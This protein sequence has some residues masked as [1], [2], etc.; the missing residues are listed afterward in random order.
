MNCVLS[1]GQLLGLDADKFNAEDLQQQG[2]SLLDGRLHAQVW[3][4]CLISCCIEVAKMRHR[5]GPAQGLDAAK[6]DAI[7]QQ[8]QRRLLLDGPPLEASLRN[9]LRL[10]EA[11]CGVKQ[12]RCAALALT[13]AAAT[14]Y[15]VCELGHQQE[16]L[17]DIAL[18]QTGQQ[19]CIASL[20]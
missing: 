6:D 5:P 3:S 11:C 17:Q 14:G 16:Q 20:Q 2:C 4:P 7:S 19:V 9:A 18:K 8:Q 12:T 13:A 1:L 15:L 10:S